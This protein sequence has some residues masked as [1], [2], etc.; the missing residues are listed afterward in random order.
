MPEDGQR[1]TWPKQRK[2]QDSQKAADVKVMGE[3]EDFVLEA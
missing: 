3:A 1:L 2:H